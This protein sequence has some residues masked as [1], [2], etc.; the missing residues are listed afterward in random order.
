MPDDT[1]TAV[2]PGDV[3]QVAWDLAPLVDGE[4]APGALRLLDE[5]EER[6]RAFADAYAGKVADL[7]SAGLREAMLEL[8]AIEEL[9][10]RAGTYAMLRFAVDTADPETGALLQRVQER[11]TTIE[12]TLLFSWNTASTGRRASRAG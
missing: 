8:G 4:E 6:A 2:G 11:G 1:I 10:G 12:T 7:D 5:A 3:E 9:A